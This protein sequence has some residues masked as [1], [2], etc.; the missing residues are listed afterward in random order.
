[1]TIPQESKLQFSLT[2][3]N[4]DLTNQ[5]TCRI[6]TLRFLFSLEQTISNIQS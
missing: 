5:T 1:M 2:S 4:L 3:Q 6:K